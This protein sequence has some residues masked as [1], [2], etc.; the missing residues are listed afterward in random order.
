MMEIVTGIE[1]LV[2][3]VSTNIREYWRLQLRDEGAE[4]LAPDKEKSEGNSIVIFP[5]KLEL[6][7]DM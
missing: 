7:L 2:V 5:I 1:K 6:V 3:V 4:Q